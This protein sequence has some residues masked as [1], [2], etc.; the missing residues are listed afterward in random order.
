MSFRSRSAALLTLV[1]TLGGAMPAAWAG[2]MVTSNRDRSLAI[3]AWGGASE[4]VVLRLHNAC[5]ITNPDCTFTYR[6]GLLISDR[7]TGLA[8]KAGRLADGEPLILSASC[9]VSRREC[10]WTYRDGMFVSDADPALAINAAGG[11]RYG[12]VL[13]LSRACRPNNPDCTWTR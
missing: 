11:A 5:R 2:G 4:G 10:S 9:M 1:A 13:R 3:N 8:I 12:T 7:N 6:G